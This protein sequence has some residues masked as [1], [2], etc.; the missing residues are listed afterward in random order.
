MGKRLACS[1]AAVPLCLSVV[2]CGA[3]TGTSKPARRAAAVLATGRRSTTAAPVTAASMHTATV[4]LAA[5]RRPG[6]D[7]TYDQDESASRRWEEGDDREIETYGR[8][9]TAV[10]WRQAAAFAHAYF[11]AAATEDGAAAC[12]LLTPG[13][14]ASLGGGKHNTSDNPPYLRGKTCAQVMSKLFAHRHKLMVAEAAGL[15]V[16]DVRVTEITTF[17]LLAFKGIR[18]RRYMGVESRNDS[19]PKLEALFDSQYP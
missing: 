4:P 11:R 12:T 19:P 6:I 8:P 2:A 14:R 9:A 7:D 17:I 15:E 1:I 5:P 3:T 18:E 16:T 13:L 10:E